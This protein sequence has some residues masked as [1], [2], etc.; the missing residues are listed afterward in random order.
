MAD[1]TIT[2]KHALPHDKAK[3]AAQQIA[4]KMAQRY[5]MQSKWS[6]DVLIFQRSGVSGTLAVHAAEARLEITLGF[7]FKAFAGTIEQ[8]VGKNMRKLFGGDKA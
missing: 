6:G 1:I 3:A 8:E 7:L 4:D 2:Q 5:D